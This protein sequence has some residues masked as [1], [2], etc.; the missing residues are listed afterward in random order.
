MRI[1]ISQAILCASVL[2]ADNASAVSLGGGFDLELE[3]TAVSDYRSY[4][5]S[6][7]LGDPTLQTS[8]TLVSPIGA[9]VGVWAS[10]VDFGEG[11]KSSREADY[12]AGWYLPIGEDLLVDIG[13]LKY[14]YD[15]DSY[16]NQ[17]GY[18]ASL[19]YKG[20][21]LDLKHSDNLYG[22][23]TNSYVAL[24]YEY[25]FNDSTRINVRYG[26]MDFK[27]EVIFSASGDSRSKYA[28]W[29]ARIE[30]DYWGATWKA[31][32]IDTDMSATECMNMSG[33]DD[34]CSASLVLSA[35]KLF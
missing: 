6:Q 5:I 28:E 35:T 8:A 27:D 31:S 14:T 16:L 11:T 24:S 33:Y 29:E 10:G 2:A 25:P 30:K 21:A 22:D 17:S 32:L 3:L 1:M 15:K 13:W 7:T 12:Y 4:G 18:Y 19:Y 20:F 23:Q 9:Y 26:V 34:L